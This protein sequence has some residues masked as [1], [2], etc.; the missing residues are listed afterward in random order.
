VF[1]LSWLARCILVS[2]LRHVGRNPCRCHLSSVFNT[3]M[4]STLIQHAHTFTRTLI[5]LD[6]TYVEFNE[7]V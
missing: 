7:T 6:Y 5:S 1:S 4:E 3:A 2:Q